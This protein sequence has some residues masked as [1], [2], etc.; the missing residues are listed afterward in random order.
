MAGCYNP[1]GGMGYGYAAPSYGYGYG[2]G[3]AY[4]QPA[5]QPVVFSPV[6]QAPTYYNYGYYPSVPQTPIRPMAITAM[7]RARAVT[8]APITCRARSIATP[9]RVTPNKLLQRNGLIRRA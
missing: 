6:Q 9:V 2:G 3:Y 1:C 5:P 8:P 7:R 4:A